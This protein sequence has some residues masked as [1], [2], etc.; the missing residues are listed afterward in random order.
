[1]KTPMQAI[2]VTGIITGHNQLELN[3]PLPINGPKEVRVIVIYPPDDTRDETMWLQAAARNPVFDF[4]KDSA[5][6]I[7]TLNDGQPFRIAT[8]SRGQ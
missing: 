3:E 7:Y 2:E 5:E 4:L 6:D 1:M 8:R